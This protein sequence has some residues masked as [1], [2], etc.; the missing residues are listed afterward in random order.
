[1]VLMKLF[2]K[3]SALSLAQQE[4]EDAQ[5]RLL[6]AQSGYEYAKRIADYHADRINRLTKY[7]R[8]NHTDGS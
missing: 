3:P 2:R 4:L 5:R 8:E 1:M 6:E 7:L